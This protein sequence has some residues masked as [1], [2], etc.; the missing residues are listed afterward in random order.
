MSN[1]TTLDRLK[2]ELNEKQYY[3][4]ETLSIYLEENNLDGNVTYTV[5][6]KKQLFQTVYDILQ[7]LA[8]NLDLFRSV[9]TE[10]ATTSAAYKYLQQ[11]LE[12]IEKKILS[13]PD[14]TGEKE[15]I[16]NFMYHD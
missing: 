2:I 16:F 5:K 1:I 6:M 4:D 7:S 10:F 8:N 12:D 11:R 13:I 14:S 3:S 15:S 9:E